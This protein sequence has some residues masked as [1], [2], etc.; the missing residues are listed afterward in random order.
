M[1]NGEEVINKMEEEMVLQ[2]LV[3]KNEELTETVPLYYHSDSEVV[4][5]DGTMGIPAGTTVSFDTYFNS[6]LS[7]TW[8]KYTDIEQIQICVGV[9]G[10]GEAVL[11][12]EKEE[13]AQ[14]QK[15]SGKTELCFSAKL[16]DSAFFFLEITAEEESVL[17][18]GRVETEAKPQSVILALATCTYNRQRD[19]KK[20]VAL[21][22]TLTGPKDE[23]AV[24]AQVFVVDNASNLIKEEIEGDG[25]WLI[26]NKNTGGA[27][28]FTRG[29]QEALKNRD[30][31]HIILM[32][33]DVHIEPE[34]FRRTKAFL[35]YI[36]TEYKENFIGGAMFRTDTPYVLHAAGE[37][38]ADGRIRNVYKSTDMR[39]FEQV[40]E[41]SVPVETEQAY[42]GWWYCCIPRCHVEQK[43]YPM[44]FFLHCDDVEYSLRSGR[45]PIYLNGIAV[46]HEEFE[47]KRSSVIEYYDTRNRLITNALYMQRGKSRTVAVI[48]TER[49]LASV[50]RYRYRDVELIL[51]A[52]EDFLKGPKWLYDLDAESYHKKLAVYGY[53]PEP[54][55][56]RPVHESGKNRGKLRTIFRYF[57]PASGKAVL[58]IGVLVGEYAGKKEVLLIDTKSGKGFTVRKSWKETILYAR[59]L[60]KRSFQLL[61]RYETI[62]IQWKKRGNL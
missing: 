4:V 16:S 30:I 17:E 5:A 31:T 2:Q 19:I 7:K 36:K 15:F 25:I 54:V 62:E 10:K 57:L 38:W 3:W 27:G 41:I 33:D 49:F 61:I 6:F 23:E 37:D 51:L 26:P 32:D 14:K 24:L 59:K 42:S 13:H 53:K 34:A 52:V 8:K 44:P 55:E 11:K 43:G 50:L 12:G 9:A 1:A 47:D 22:K 21:L 48:L 20:N 60:L 35:S 40:L 18:Y 39:K 29:L 46:W 45:P 58:K 56:G 28:G